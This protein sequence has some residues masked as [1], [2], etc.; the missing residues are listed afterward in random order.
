MRRRYAPPAPFGWLSL[1]PASACRTATADGAAPGLAARLGDAPLLFREAEQIV[2]AHYRRLYFGLLL[3]RGCSSR[4]ICLRR[5]Y[6]IL[7]Y[8]L[9]SPQGLL[10]D[11]LRLFRPCRLFLQDGFRRRTH[12]LPLSPLA[13]TFERPRDIHVAAYVEAFVEIL[14]EHTPQIRCD[15]FRAALV[16]ID[17]CGLA[18]G[19]GIQHRFRMDDPFGMAVQVFVG[20][21]TATVEM[22]PAQ[23]LVVLGQLFF[24]DAVRRP[25]ASL[26]ENAGSKTATSPNGMLEAAT[27]K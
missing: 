22:Y 18:V 16:P 6:R 10:P 21:E 5:P 12:L 14:R 20:V 4:L 23:R 24:W 17:H 9:L 8:G 25:N 1:S 2:K 15:A 11:C 27:S 26:A 13:D 19:I 7:R 3:F